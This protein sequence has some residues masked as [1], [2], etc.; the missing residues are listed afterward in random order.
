MN[1]IVVSMYRASGFE[2]ENE[3]RLREKTTESKLDDENFF[4]LLRRD[5]SGGYEIDRDEDFTSI[6]GVLDP[7]TTYNAKISPR[8]NLARHA[9]DL[10]LN[11]IIGVNKIFKFS[12]G[13]QNYTMSSQ[14]N[15][16]IAPVAEDSDIDLSGVEALYYPDLY[17]FTSKLEFDEFRQ[18]QLNPRGTFKFNDWDGIKREGF[19]LSCKYEKEKNEAQVS[20]EINIMSVIYSVGDSGTV[21]KSVDN[22]LSWVTKTVPAA[23]NLHSIFVKS[24]TELIVGGVGRNVYRSTNGGDTWSTIALP[25]YPGEVTADVTKIKFFDSSNGALIVQDEGEP[26]TRYYTTSDGGLTWFLKSAVYKIVDIAFVT[27]SLWYAVDLSGDVIKTNDAGDT[28]FVK[29]GSI[30]GVPETIDEFNNTLFITLSGGAYI[31]I[32]NEVFGSVN[33]FIS[34]SGSKVFYGKINTRAYSGNDRYNYAGMQ[35]SVYF[36][37]FKVPPLKKPLFAATQNMNDV[38]YFDANIIIWVGDAGEIVR[39]DNGLIGVSASSSIIT[40]GTSNILNAVHGYNDCSINID[41]VVVVNAIG[42]NNGQITINASGF[43]TPEYRIVN[44]SIAFDSGYLPSNVFNN[45]QQGEYDVFVRESG[46]T[47]QDTDTATVLFYET[48]QA[49]ISGTDLTSVGADDG[50]AQ[51]TVTS[52]SGSYSYLWSTTETTPSI[53]NLP[54]GF[55]TVVVTDDI[56]LQEVNLGIAINDPTPGSAI[57]PFL[58]VPQ[59]NSLQFVREVSPDCDTFQDIDRV[60]FCKQE[61][62]FYTKKNY[63]Q[64]VAKCDILTIQ[65]QSNF[66]NHE[67][68]LLD[69][70][71]DAVIDNYSAELKRQLTDQTQEWVVNLQN[72]GNNQTRVYYAPGGRFPV[73]PKSSEVI[74][75]KNNLDGFN[76]NYTIISLEFDTAQGTEYIVINKLYDAP[77]PQ[78]NADADY[79]TNLLDFNIFEFVANFGSVADGIYYMK[80]RGFDEFGN[81]LTAVSEPIDLKTTQP[82]A[83]F[84]RFTNNDN[85]Y[86]V[87][88]T[89]G[90]IHKL[91]VK[92]NNFKR[93]TGS[94]KEVSRNTDGTLNNLSNKPRRVIELEFYDL[95]PYMHEKLAIAFEH[96]FA[97]VNEIQYV[98]EEGYNEPQYITRYSLSNST[99]R[100]EQAQWFIT[101]NS[102]D[103]GQDDN[104]GDDLL[105]VNEGFLKL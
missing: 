47:C 96:D 6:D 57:D 77:A 95:P 11:V 34:P 68:Q 48:L 40:S 25:L 33:S 97:F 20:L 37:K 39:T 29:I 42:G 73:T 80:I 15:S 27:T 62:P 101:Y 89:T 5:G 41:S 100:L 1:L 86:D 46:S 35:S 84:I 88:Y 13:E 78:S 21:I 2:I 52:G 60:L 10:A 74:T 12:Y 90:I 31:N 7:S 102:T 28:A 79:T 75:I 8:R 71:T 103:T 82:D 54:V 70:K 65:F 58:E 94:D 91:R 104:G 18:I 44:T 26:T 9:K 43:T 51:V 93:F 59:I 61:F 76:G 3:R 14:L 56:T 85:A 16:E 22:G 64:L 83:V 66:P 55:Y 30:I 69:Y 98:T 38:F 99:I 23:V 72:H 92:A 49:S 63:F 32:D 50:T 36:N 87:D 24:D 19:L 67:I 17:N 45:L 4:I 105:I 81:E 53:Q